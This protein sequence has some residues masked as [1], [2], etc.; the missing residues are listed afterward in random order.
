MVQAWKRR[1]A[2]SCHRFI[3]ELLVI[4]LDGGGSPRRYLV[5]RLLYW[6]L[7][8]QVLIWIKIEEA[9]IFQMM[10]FSASQLIQAINKLI[11]SG[12]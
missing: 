10:Q 3:F 6:A 5:V 7:L 2:H 4:M 8:A 1:P 11:K 9:L 12:C